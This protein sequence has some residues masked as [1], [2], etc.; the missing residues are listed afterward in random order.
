MIIQQHQRWIPP[1]KPAVNKLYLQTSR[2]ALQLAVRSWTNQ[3]R[4]YNKM[5]DTAAN[6]AI[7]TKNFGT[8]SIQAGSTQALGAAVYVK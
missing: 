6:I 3:Y 7:D 1:K 2:L 4:E 8:T 5:A